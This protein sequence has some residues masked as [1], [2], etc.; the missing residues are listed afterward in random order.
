MIDPVSGEIAD[1]MEKMTEGILY[2]GVDHWPS[3]TARDSSEHFSSKLGPF[4]PNIIF[5][6]KTKS[7]KES[8][9]VKEVQSAV[10]CNNGKME[11]IF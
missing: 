7:V 9:L 1:N 5:S 8:G 2:L 4:I 6:D 11:E 10:I 3:E